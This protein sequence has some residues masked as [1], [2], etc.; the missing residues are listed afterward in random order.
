MSRRNLADEWRLE[1]QDVPADQWKLE[2][3]EQN[4]I[5]QW[6]LRDE[7]GGVDPNEWQPVSYT[8]ERREPRVNWVLPS[9]VGIALV[10]VIAYVAWIAL[11]RAGLFGP[12]APA[13]TPTSAAAVA[14]EPGEVTE[15]TPTDTPVP[16]TPTPEPPPTPTLEPTAT[17][18]PLVN[19]ES[20]VVTGLGGVNAR[21]E[22]SL[23]SEILQVLPQDETAYLVVADQGEWIQVALPDTRLA[24]V[25]AEFVQRRSE[26]VLT[27]VANQRRTAV[28]LPPLEL[29]A[30][31]PPGDESPQVEPGEAVTVTTPPLVAPV[32]ISATINITA[33]LNARESPDLSSPVVQLLAGNTT[34]TALARSEDNQW[35]QILLPDGRLAW[36]SSQFVT[37]GG[38]LQ[39]LSTD[40]ATPESLAATRAAIAPPA[41]PI[42]T[43]TP[44]TPTTAVTP[45]VTQVVDGVTATVTNLA[46]A[47]AR[48]VPQRE[49]ETAQLLSFGAVLPVVGRSADGEWVQLTLEEGRLAWVLIS[50]VTLSADSASLPIVTP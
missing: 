34:Y 25:A 19:V 31:Q 39:S 29:P 24:W 17:P 22:P 48:A 10:A 37:L 30:S 44:L 50:A 12:V 43:T 8:R 20:I 11:E 9:L 7:A 40:P 1:E 42:T 15:P 21:S 27:E 47:N 33:G 49:A 46:G 28:G 3:A 16:P 32:T 36:V 23:Q 38:D 26:T 5:A 2:P 14:T 13:P 41:E 6:Q 45:T 35:V 4:A 18:L